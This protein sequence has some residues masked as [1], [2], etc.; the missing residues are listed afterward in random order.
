MSTCRAILES[1]AAM[2]ILLADDHDV[3]RWG[4][5]ALI[6]GQPDMSVVGEVA[7]GDAAISRAQ[8]LSPDIVVLD[9]SMPGPGG[10]E[11]IGR[12]RGTC[13]TVRVLVLTMHDDQVLARAA[14]SAGAAGFVVKSA[15]GDQLLSAL[16]SVHRGHSFVT[17]S[18][19]DG[20]LEEIVA[21]RSG[22]GAAAV[23]PRPLSP[24]ER[25]VLTLLARGHTYQETADYLGISVKSVGTYRARLADKLALSTRAEL[26]RYALET[27]LIR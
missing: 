26:V 21:Q 27:G 18:L 8:E 24:R 20:S 16:R 23:G 3:V 7:T 17:V 1:M 19:E 15:A 2:R 6:G 11:V 5:S 10:V 22:S 14:L 4:L 25:E 9:L 12:L 13:P